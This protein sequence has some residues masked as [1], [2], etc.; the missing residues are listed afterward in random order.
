MGS[1][2]APMFTYALPDGA[3]STARTKRRDASGRV[4]RLKTVAAIARAVSTA[5]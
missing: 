2:P 1:A 4:D 3:A 5:G